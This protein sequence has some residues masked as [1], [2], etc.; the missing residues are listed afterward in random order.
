MQASGPRMI[1]VRTKCQWDKIV[2]LTTGDRLVVE[3]TI[4]VLDSSMIK[5]HAN[6]KFTAELAPEILRETGYVSSETMLNCGS[7][8]SK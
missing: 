6:G 7:A 2:L 1:S 5:E 3:A 8:G 4:N